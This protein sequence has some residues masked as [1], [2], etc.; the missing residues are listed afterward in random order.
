MSVLL[1]ASISFDSSV[2]QLFP[3]LLHGATLVMVTEEM[4]RDPRAL[5]AELEERKI[6][7]WDC[8]PGYLAYL[9]P[10]IRHKDRFPAYTLAGGEMLGREVIRQYYELFGE[11]SRLINVYGVTE[12]T[13][14]STFCITSPEMPGIANIG[15]PLPGTEIYLLDKNREIAPIGFAGEICIGG[16]GL[17]RGYLY[18]EALTRE[19][20]IDNPHGEGR[21]YCTGDLGKWLPDGSIDFLGRMDRQVKVSGH[22]VELAEVEN[23]LTGHRDIQSVVVVAPED[24]S[25]DS[26]IAAY[27]VSNSFLELGEIKTF[28]EKQL[29]AYMMPSWFIPLPVL[30]L[31]EHGK[32]DIRQLPDPATAALRG[33]GNHVHAE[34][35]LERKLS[36]IWEELLDYKDVGI[37]VNFFDIGGNSM[38]VIQLHQRIRK[39]YPDSSLE[40]YQIFSHPTIKELA[41]LLREGD[42]LGANITKEISVIEL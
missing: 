32:I 22:R 28:L 16:G 2:K 41:H 14:D 35:A 13:V 12:A 23:A 39:D 24:P 3:A 7:I 40:I 33:S 17:A 20:F 15:K 4:H 8:T 9:L 34:D 5:A 11:R 21:L 1:N 42:R 36:G 30:P 29:P 37:H 18:D 26:R 38:K 6:D 10:E 19:K 31:N 25:G 27:F